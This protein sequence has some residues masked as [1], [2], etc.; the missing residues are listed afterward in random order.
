MFCGP[1]PQNPSS[2]LR[3]QSD[4]AP[5]EEGVREVPVSIPGG[6]GLPIHEP[7]SILGLG[8]Q[9]DLGAGVYSVRYSPFGRPMGVSAG[10]QRRQG[11]ENSE[12][13]RAS[14]TKQWRNTIPEAKAGESR[15]LQ[16]PPQP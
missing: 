1:Y 16:R 15:I 9:R 7:F 6:L 12:E 3:V 13:K 4:V 5:S 11:R 10:S 14:L 8:T 2:F